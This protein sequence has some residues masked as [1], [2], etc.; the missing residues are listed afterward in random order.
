MSRP[1][2]KLEPTRAVPPRWLVAPFLRP[3][4][5]ELEQLRAALAYDAAND[6]ETLLTRG[7]GS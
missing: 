2:E 5:E 3:K 4:I 6:L 1:L 7:H